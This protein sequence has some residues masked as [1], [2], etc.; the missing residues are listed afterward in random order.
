MN[1]FERTLINLFSS[2]LS[3]T[4]PVLLSFLTTPL[5]VKY[6]GD[7]SYGIKGIIASTVGYFVL[8]DFGINGAGTKYL[9]EYIV[10]NENEN[11]EKLLGTTLTTYFVFGLFGSIII[12]FLSDWF[13]FSL[14]M[15]PTELR[16]NSMIAFKISAIGFLL[17]MISWWGAS[18]TS[19]LQRFY[20]Y[21][22][23]NIVTLLCNVLGGLIAAKLGYGI[24]GVIIANTSSYL[25]TI[26]LNLLCA[27]ILLPQIRIRFTIDKE[28]FKKTIKFGIYMFLFQIFAIIFSQLDKTILGV[29]IGSTAVTYYIIPQSIAS[30][31]HDA[32]AR[33]MQI[34]FPMTSEFV[35]ANDNKKISLIFYRGAT[36][37][38]VV[39]LG[40]SIPLITFS[41]SILKFWMDIE[42]AHKSTNVLLIL[43]A[44]YFLMGLTAMPT[45]FIGGLG[46]PK[47]IP[48]G[49]FITGSIG[50]LFY[51]ILIKPFGINGAALSRC[52]SMFITVIYYF[53]I[54][55]KVFNKI[56]FIHT[57]LLIIK[58]II[59]CSIVIISVYFIS[60]VLIIKNL[61]HIIIYSCIGMIEYLFLIWY[62]GVLYPN[63]KY[64]IIEF[65]KKIFFNKSQK[66]SSIL[67]N[68]K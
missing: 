55:K 1:R 18:I 10:K 5:L 68:Y 7:A 61:F 6:L 37:S 8:L 16:Y 53:Y 50:L 2:G 43:I 28:I 29:L 21:N 54:C 47:Y 15:I 27:K 19:G 62:G 13:A 51:C 31:I 35:T 3:W 26:I 30:L 42:F 32:N 11:I 40:I 57:I 38:V 9:A 48:I 25:V 63:E 4:I 17:S 14:F 49:S 12:W 45:S 24:I 20:L 56:S 67:S 41:S 33:L 23:I 59:A 34:I 39:G 52:I 65:L 44:T 46:F 36:L 66:A 64:Q 22:A 60:H 58:P